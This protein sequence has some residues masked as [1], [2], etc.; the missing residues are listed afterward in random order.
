MNNDFTNYLNYIY[1]LLDDNMTPEEILSSSSDEKYIYG[2]YFPHDIN[3]EKFEDVTRGIIK[4][5]FN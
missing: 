4:Q 1:R 5:Y 3:F 2:I